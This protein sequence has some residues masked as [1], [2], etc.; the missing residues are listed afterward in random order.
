MSN[1]SDKLLEGVSFGPDGVEYRIPFLLNGINDKSRHVIDING[2][3][4][5]ATVARNRKRRKMADEP[6]DVVDENVFQ[7]KDDSWTK[8]RVSQTGLDDRLLQ[9]RFPLVVA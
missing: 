8:N 3:D 7:S 1:E 6:S 2:A 9:L 5:V 4:P